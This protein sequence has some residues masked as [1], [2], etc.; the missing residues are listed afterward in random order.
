MRNLCP[1]VRRV[2]TR[3]H[4]HAHEIEKIV[5]IARP[6][7]PATIES[8][9]TLSELNSSTRFRSE[10]LLLHRDSCPLQ[11]HMTPVQR[12]V[13]SCESTRLQLSPRSPTSG[14][15]P[16]S[17]QGRCQRRMK[18]LPG[19]LTI[20]RSTG[21]RLTQRQMQTSIHNASPCTTHPS[22]CENCTASCESKLKPCAA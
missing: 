11:C 9:L 14:L 16:E 18:P 2:Q 21:K 8:T 5:V 19:L 3:H 17:S 22:E 1:E 12:K 4:I 10:D 7:R 15:V 20:Y 13:M 6:R